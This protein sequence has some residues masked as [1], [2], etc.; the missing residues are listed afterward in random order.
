M[1]KIPEETKSEAV[2]KELKRLV[3][4]VNYT[5]SINAS[6]SK[7]DKSAVWEKAKKVG[8]HLPND[9]LSIAAPTAA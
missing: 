8:K 2:I 3:F 1:N 7:A 6:K 4:E 9:S 5:E